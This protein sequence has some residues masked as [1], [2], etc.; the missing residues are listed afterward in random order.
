MTKQPIDDEELKERIEYYVQ[1]I[2]DKNV[3]DMLF[4]ISHRNNGASYNRQSEKV[5]SLHVP[6]VMR[7]QVGEFNV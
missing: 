2:R 3:F 5:V 1:A 4:D 7:K 6:R